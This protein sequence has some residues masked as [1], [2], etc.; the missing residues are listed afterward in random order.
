M[1]EIDV[2][3]IEGVSH[4]FLGARLFGKSKSACVDVYAQAGQTGC[5]SGMNI[6]MQHTL[7]MTAFAAVKT[8]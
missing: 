3:P 6:G 8:C 1:L 7:Y 5:N 2:R 4:D